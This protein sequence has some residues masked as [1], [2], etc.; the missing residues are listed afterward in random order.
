MSH[1]K[2]QQHL[3]KSKRSST[4]Y[5]KVQT[6]ASNKKLPGMQKR[7]IQPT[8]RKSDLEITQVIKLA[9]KDNKTVGN[10]L[11]IFRT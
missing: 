8:M 4:Q 6:V 2:A 1:S 9:C 7:K 10:G 3:Q 5:S 11:H